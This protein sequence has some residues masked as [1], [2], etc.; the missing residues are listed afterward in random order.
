MEIDD[1]TNKGIFQRVR[2]CCNFSLLMGILYLTSALI[3]DFYAIFLIY[4]SNIDV[5]LIV[6]FI[7]FLLHVLYRSITTREYFLFVPFWADLLATISLIFE[8]R[9]FTAHIMPE[10]SEA[11]EISSERYR[12]VRTIYIILR[13]L[14]LGRSIRYFRRCIYYFVDEE[15]GAVAS[16]TSYLRNILNNRDMVLIF[17]LVIVLP[18]LD[19]AFVDSSPMAWL[20]SAGASL[21]CNSDSSP[22]LN[23]SLIQYWFEDLT[24]FYPSRYSSLR[25]VE[26]TITASGGAAVSFKKEWSDLPSNRFEAADSML[27]HYSIAGPCLADLRL[28]LDMRLVAQSSAA[29]SLALYLML[30]VLTVLTSVFQHKAI[31]SLVGAPFQRMMLLVKRSAAVLLQ[32]FKIS[33]GFTNFDSAAETEIMSQ[34]GAGNFEAVVYQCTSVRLLSIT[35]FHCIVC[36]SNLILFCFLSHVWNDVARY[37]GMLH[38]I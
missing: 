32:G 14:R 3:P 34:F 35:R 37:D 10:E 20:R 23:S 21:T 16:L 19:Y 6:L 1:V 11:L 15:D 2:K 13:L 7:I 22:D 5:L 24:S 28:V 36:N 17:C 26:A 9:R 4:D 25:L 38:M 33:S 27:L 31:G 30:L 12:A 29:L 18:Y 8:I